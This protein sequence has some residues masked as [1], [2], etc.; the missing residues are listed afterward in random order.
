MSLALTVNVDRFVF[1]ISSF[2][3]W[4]NSS[5]DQMAKHQVNPR[6]TLA[7]DKRGR[8]VS[9]RDDWRTCTAYPVAV[10]AINPPANGISLNEKTH[11]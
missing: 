9:T 11:V 8:V 5:G 4:N 10:Y 2:Q 1:R 3:D 6:N 7:I